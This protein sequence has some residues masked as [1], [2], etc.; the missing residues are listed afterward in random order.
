[1]NKWLEN[2]SLVQQ[3]D[4]LSS[5]YFSPQGNVTMKGRM[6]WWGGLAFTFV[7]ALVSFYLGKLPGLDHVGAL[8]C[9]IL[10]AVAY[11]QFAG[12][13]E[14]LRPGIQ[15]ASKKLLR[16]AII[17]FGLKLN[18]DVVLSQGL[19]LLARDV[20]VIVFAITA[21][22]LLSK[23]LKADGSLSLLLG[24]G[25]GVCGAAA[26]AAVSPIVK[27]KEEDTAISA[28]L[29]AL[30]G[31]LFAIAYTVIR[32][33]MPFT[34]LEYGTWA[35]ISLHE[36]AHVAL[37]GAPAGT[38]GLAMALL[39][40]L[41]RVLLLVPLSFILF[42]W[43]NRRARKKHEVRS[44]IH[45]GEAA[46]RV[47]YATQGNEADCS[48]KMEFP[49]FLVGFIVMSLIGSYVFGKIIIVPQ[50][51]LES[52]SFITSF[53]ISMAMIGLGLNV[54]LKEVRNKAMR[55]L[56]VM[57]IVSLMLSGLAYLMV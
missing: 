25:T 9:A 36:M 20:I 51:L 34:Q 44:F 57:V 39:A 11:R 47:A 5:R 48:S 16:F 56:L 15:F 52:V 10:I 8:A 28:G 26:I 43:M 50:R 29:I 23:W 33:F 22:L 12:Y 38:D 4:K 27:A 24:I 1:M 37:A 40:K 32:P 2:P 42:Y 55:P 14:A 3:A 19:G 18:I 13:P 7:I 30:V 31:T 54:D 45:T 17:L 41:G 49:W 21:T 53:M 46:G 35:G 6:Q